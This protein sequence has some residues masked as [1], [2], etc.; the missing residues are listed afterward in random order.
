MAQKCRNI[1]AINLKS[2]N[3]SESDKII[4][5]YSKESGLIRGVAKGCKKPKS[6]LGA[7]MD[8]LVANSLMIS[9]GRNLNTICEARS[10]NTFRKTREDMDKLMYSSYISEVTAAFGVENDP[11]SNEVY[12]VLYKALDR[13]SNAE[14]KVE[15]LV[16]VLKFQLKF[17]QITGFGIEFESCL[18]CQ[19]PLKKEDIY[20]SANRGGV[21][22]QN[23]LS[24]TIVSTKLHY[25]IR[26]FL[27]ELLNSDFDEHLQYERKA[28]EKVCLVCFD[29]LKKYVQ[30][31]CAKQ[32]KSVHFLETVCN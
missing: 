5:M 8:L 31:H 23:C 26:D 2:Y 28:T 11:C 32:I 3:L 15:V 4:V 19:K 7:R 20:F 16:A 29:M 1:D 25:K 30:L 24:D 9:N 22:C 14:N 10:I 12:D 27:V 6:K 13:I 21:I 18:C 17:M